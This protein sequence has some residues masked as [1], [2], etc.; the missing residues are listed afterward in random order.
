M[1]VV[2]AQKLV[3]GYVRLPKGQMVASGILGKLSKSAVSVISSM[4][5]ESLTGCVGF[6]ELE[7]NYFEN[8]AGI[9]W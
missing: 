2:V 3:G 4:R 8:R 1:F 5:F 6:M 7:T 9:R